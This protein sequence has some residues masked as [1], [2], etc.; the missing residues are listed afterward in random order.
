MAESF[1]VDVD[2]YDRA[3]P[4][5]PAELV[6]RIVA[7][8]PGLDLLDVG[9][10]T[11]IEARQFRDAG[12]RVLGVDPDARMAA[13]A[14]GGGIDVEVA[15]FEDWE[16]A[17]R[18][19]DAVVSGQAWHWVD[20]VA[21]PA[22]AAGVL[23]PDGL[24]AVFA[25]VF[26]PPAVVADAFAGAIRRVLPGSPFAGE[27]RSAD[28]IYDLMFTRFA[29]GIRDAGGFGEPERWR[30]EWER[31]YTRDE[32][33]DFLPTTGGLTRLAPEV[34]ADV[35]D[36]VGA[37]IDGLGGSFVLPYATLAAAARKA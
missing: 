17:G 26:Q 13:F 35:L 23:R 10:G 20:P 3:R 16:P 9:C 5:Y 7:E 15:T 19:F 22:K 21:G 6:A 8:S 28:E 18:A 2:R 11:G 34:L 14:R 31:S 24:L 33:L 30:F 12:C 25:H 36:G 29:D 32:W 27:S 1:G 4:D 37:A